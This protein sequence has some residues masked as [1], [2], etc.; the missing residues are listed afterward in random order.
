MSLSDFIHTQHR[1]IVEEWVEFA[2]TMHPWS[3]GMSE[4]DLKD[5]AEE[6]LK[7]VVDDMKL[8]QSDDEQA[9]KSKGNTADGKPGRVGRMHATER[10]QS[11]LSLDQLVSEFR[12][13]RASVLRLWEKAHGD[14]QSE[15]TRF[16]EAI[17]EALATSVAR[18]TELVG[19]TR[20][21]FLAILGH[22]LRNPIGSVT[23]GASLL[24]ES[25]DAETVDIATSILGSGERMSRMVRDLLD[26]TR[27][28]LGAGIPVTLKPMELEP[29]CRQVISELHAIHPKRE[30]R[31]A[32]SGD[33]RGSWDS[34]RIA[35]VV[36]N[37][38]ANALQYGAAGERV[39]VVAVG[40]AE[41]VT[42][43]VHNFGAP[44]PENALRSIFAPMTRHQAD[45]KQS[46]KNITGLGLGLFIASEIVTAHRGTIGVTSSAE[47]GTTFTV[48]IPRAPVLEAKR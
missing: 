27:T 9:E 2:R 8:P 24:M 5:H 43:Q 21:Q 31:F 33:L 38:V 7:A 26:L 40:N 45:G 20:E 13:L 17:D 29:V 11:G 35:Q 25:T 12:A 18:H 3:E 22:D 4:K 47:K 36:S 15:M 1:L 14:Q 6:L 19:N 46:S 30:V 37:L 28:R 44:I 32:A 16:N 39:S 10:L 41:D 34:D 48:R 42:L 23:M